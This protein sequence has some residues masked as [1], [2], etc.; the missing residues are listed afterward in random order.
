[1]VQADDNLFLIHRQFTREKL[2][3]Y[4]INSTGQYM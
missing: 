3:Y 1:M 2:M 4:V